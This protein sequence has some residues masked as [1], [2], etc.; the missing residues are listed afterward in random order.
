MQEMIFTLMGKT[1]TPEVQEIMSKVS[2]LI[3]AGKTNEL[4]PELLLF[5]FSYI[6]LFIR[7]LVKFCNSR[8]PYFGQSKISD[9]Q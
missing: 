4:I 5:Q 9:A 2:R 3:I 6:F 1:G 7:E 8:S